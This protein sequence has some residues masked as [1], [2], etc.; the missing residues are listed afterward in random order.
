MIKGFNLKE[1]IEEAILHIK[2]HYV[3]R[4]AGIWQAIELFA[5]M[6]MRVVRNFNFSCSIPNTIKELQI[7]I[8]ADQPWSEVHFKER[9][10]GRPLNPGESYKIW[11][12]NKDSFKDLAFMDGKLFSHTYM[13][14]YWPKDANEE[15]NPLADKVGIRYHYGDLKDVIEQLKDNQLTRQAYLPIFFPE[16]TGALHKMR[17]PCSLGYLFEIWDG[18]LDCSYYIRSCD[19]FRHFRNDIY[20]TSRLM[21]HVAE[22]IPGIEVGKLNMYVAN[23]HLFENDLYAFNKKEK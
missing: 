16:D 3:I 5:D 23:L 2:N 1:I 12:Y 22:L 21:Q 6:D 4:K 10:E 13:E 18:K 9:V 15:N 14:R 11:P 20:L 19:I 7:Q 17:V 8:K